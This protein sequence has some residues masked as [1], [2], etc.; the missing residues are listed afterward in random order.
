MLKRQILSL[1]AAVSLALATP[2][3]ADALTAYYAGA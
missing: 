2:A 3:L 1:T